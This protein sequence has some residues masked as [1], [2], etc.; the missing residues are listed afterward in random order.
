MG[1]CRVVIDPPGFDDAP[2]IT[3]T[4]EEMLIEALVAQPAVEAFDEGVLCRLS[5]RDVVPLDAGLTDPSQDRMTGQLRPIVGDDHLRRTPLGDE[6]G[7]LPGD[8][9]AGQGDID[10][11]GQGFPG[12][13]ID[14]AER[15]EPAAIA[16][17]IRHKVQ[18][19]SFIRLLRQEHGRTRTCRPL[20][21]ASSLHGQSLLGI[22]PVDPLVIG[23][24]ALAV[25]Q[26]TEPAITEPAA[27]TGQLP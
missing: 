1:P 15:A 13:V 9:H 24:E 5:R 11:H 7:Q 3:E 6:A 26:D 20:A 19:P 10:D 14:N 21:S 25:Q 16:E 18:A 12:K 8:P 2:G 4:V 27:F 23:T 22:D 17:G